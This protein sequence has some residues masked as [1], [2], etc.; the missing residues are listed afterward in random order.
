MENKMKALWL[1]SEMKLCI[2]NLFFIDAIFDR[3]AAKA[4]AAKM[5]QFKTELTAV[6]DEMTQ[7]EIEDLAYRQQA[8]I[9]TSHDDG[10][11]PD[12]L[13]ARFK[14]ER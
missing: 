13:K 8:F 10:F 11:V 4:N 3:P 14:G 5:S 9:T 6:L 1:V 12:Y 7:A 2:K